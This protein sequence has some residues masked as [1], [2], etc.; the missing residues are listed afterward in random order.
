M[1]DAGAGIATVWWLFSLPS[2][3]VDA[4]RDAFSLFF[5]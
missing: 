1:R 4:K 2:M 3:H 5:G